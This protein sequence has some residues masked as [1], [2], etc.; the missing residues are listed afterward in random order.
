MVQK[1]QSSHQRF[2]QM[3]GTTGTIVL[4]PKIS[5][6]PARDDIHA[7]TNIKM[8]ISSEHDRRC[9]LIEMKLPLSKRCHEAGLGLG[10]SI[11]NLFVRNLTTCSSYPAGSY[12]K[13]SWCLAPSTTH[14]DFGSEAAANNS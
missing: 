14:R 5:V 6:P 1:L 4:V 9:G 13:K 2:A 10:S 3:A 12:R 11:F 7:S 8:R